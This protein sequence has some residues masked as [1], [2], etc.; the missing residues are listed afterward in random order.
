MH[1]FDI[2]SENSPEDPIIQVLARE[3]TR[4]LETKPQVVET[5]LKA[6]FINYLWAKA[7]KEQAD[8]KSQ[9]GNKSSK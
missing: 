8:L 3:T 7:E 1:F 6:P 9:N 4:E 2:A 5:I